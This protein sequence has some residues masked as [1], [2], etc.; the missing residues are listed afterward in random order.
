MWPAII[1][2]AASGGGYISPS[3]NLQNVFDG[4][5]FQ[6]WANA[7]ANWENAK[8]VE[9][10]NS[11]SEEMANT[12][13]FREVQD[14]KRAGLNPILSAGGKGAPAPT[15][16]SPGPQ[17][18]LTPNLS[19]PRVHADMVNL[20]L[21]QQKIDIDR[22]KTTADIEKIKAEIPNKK[23]QAG[24]TKAQEALTKVNVNQRDYENPGLIRTGVEWIK[25]A[26]KFGTPWSNKVK[27]RNPKTGK[28]WED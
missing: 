12:A 6:R 14:L 7:D 17:L 21:S 8:A 19:F 22:A 24:L 10:Q 23:A 25:E 13:H 2:G 9:K 5:T 16:A 28:Y 27:V 4:Y 20:L 11:W 18:G 1:G 3:K 15:S 26:T